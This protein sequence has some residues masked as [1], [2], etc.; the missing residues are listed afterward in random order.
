MF[1]VTTA[2]FDT[3]THG[4][5]YTPLPMHPHFPVL[6]VNILMAVRLNL[7][8]LLIFTCLMIS[9]V[10]LFGHLYISLEK[11]LFKSFAHFLISIF[12]LL[13]C[14]CCLY[15]VDVKAYEIRNLTI[16]S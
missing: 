10:E 14:I 3:P 7:I 5:Q 13:S 12:L 9:Y 6:S 2:L 4:A 15:T 1:S 8:V 11:F 16:L